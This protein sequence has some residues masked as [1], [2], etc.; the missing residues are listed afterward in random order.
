[1]ILSVRHNKPCV[2]HPS[3]EVLLLDQHMGSIW[4]YSVHL[5]AVRLKFIEYCELWKF[6]FQFIYF[7]LT[8]G[9]SDLELRWRKFSLHC[10]TWRCI[11]LHSMNPKLVK[12]TVGCR[13]CHINTKA[14]VQYNWSYHTRKHSGY[15]WGYS[16]IHP[17]IYIN[18]VNLRY[19]HNP[20]IVESHFSN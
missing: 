11:E 4:L 7:R 18:T 3:H 20:W 14:Y 5:L 13:I 1:M 10:I 15:T 6:S 8:P 9:R 12:M 2:L 16:K 17:H 19:L